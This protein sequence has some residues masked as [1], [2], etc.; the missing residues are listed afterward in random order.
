MYAD[1]ARFYIAVEEY[2]RTGYQS[3]ERIVDTFR[4]RAA[5]FVL[6][7]F[8]KLNA[9]STAAIKASLL[10][11]RERL[12]SQ[13]VALFA[14]LSSLFRKPSSDNEDEEVDLLNMAAVE[15]QYS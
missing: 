2:I 1:E 8:Q 11:R 12:Q 4:R 7:T 14:P 9:S 3:L 5:G 13:L 15:F 10:A 6:T